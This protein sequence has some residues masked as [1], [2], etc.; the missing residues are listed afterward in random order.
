MSPRGAFRRGTGAALGAAPPGSARPPRR[1]A[2]LR[3]AAMCCAALCYV[4]L[5]CAV[6][7]CCAAG[8]ARGAA[9]AG[10]GRG[11]WNKGAAGGGAW[12]GA[13]ALTSRPDPQGRG[14]R[15][16]RAGR[17]RLRW[18]SPPRGVPSQRPGHR[19]RRRRRR[20]GRSPAGQVRPPVPAIGV[21]SDR[22]G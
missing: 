13:A 12:Q 16:L 6:R 1:C 2:A 9:G 7:C 19:Q 14:G 8:P 10:W 4:V 20:R 17:L 22:I 18:V 21:Q 5:R 15:R 11:E 3:Y